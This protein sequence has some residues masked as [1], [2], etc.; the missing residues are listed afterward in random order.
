MPMNRDLVRASQADLRR[1]SLLAALAGS[2]GE[3]CDV[4]PEAAAEALRTV[5]TGLPGCLDQDVE[6]LCDEK[7]V[8]PDQSLA[9]TRNVTVTP[10]GRQLVEHLQDNANQDRDART[11]V[12]ASMVLC[13]VHTHEHPGTTTDVLRDAGVTVLG[14]PLPDGCVEEALKE[15]HDLGLLQGTK[16]YGTVILPSLTAEGRKAVRSGRPVLLPDDDRGGMSSVF[17][18]TITG[19]IQ[20]Q[21]VAVVSQGD[22]NQEATITLDQ[23]MTDLRIA[24]DDLYAALAG[25]KDLQ[26]K[27]DELLE[28]L[29]AAE[30]RGSKSLMARA[31]S[32][33]RRL[34]QK[35]AEKGIDQAVALA[36]AEAVTPL[37]KA[38]GS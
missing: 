31:L 20:G 6:A 28:Q 34:A 7:L 12:V 16:A 27:I 11:A 10:A 30:D 17:N 25:Q 36:V 32:G 14:L 21:N 4:D 29:N 35:A 13:Y 24:V 26:N 23:A 33:L 18:T 9:A 22:V 19:G 1:L 5:F 3:G 2:A 15:L 8:L 37:L 38:L